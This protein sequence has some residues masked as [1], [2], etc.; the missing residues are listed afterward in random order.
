[1]KEQASILE[2]ELQREQQR[3]RTLQE[4]HEEANKEVLKLRSK[5]AD[6]SALSAKKAMADEQARLDGE[7]ATMAA[8]KAEV[9]AFRTKAAGLLAEIRMTKESTG[10]RISEVIAE[11]QTVSAARMEKASSEWH[12]E[13]EALQHRFL[14][15]KTELASLCFQADEARCHTRRLRRRTAV[16]RLGRAVGTWRH[17]LCVRELRHKARRERAAGLRKLTREGEE[18]EN[19]VTHR[20]EALNKAVRLAELEDE[21][22][23]K[24][25]KAEIK[26]LRDELEQ[27]EERIESVEER[28]KQQEILAEAVAIVPIEEGDR[29]RKW[30]EAAS[31]A[32]S[33]NFRGATH[34]LQRRSLMAGLDGEDVV[35]NEVR[36]DGEDV[37]RYAVKKLRGS[38]SCPSSLPSLRGGLQGLEDRIQGCRRLP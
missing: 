38:S 23:R 37:L 9:E 8:A 6:P 3:T 17:E 12:C 24:D 1:L 19:Q 15:S 31:G 11:E 28:M 22:V 33:A 27:L 5:L 18:I 21:V 30:A 35:R 4:E 2:A 36:K 13:R 32:G 10:R 14:A 34:R 25:G 20:R 29:I 7:A 26:G 16:V